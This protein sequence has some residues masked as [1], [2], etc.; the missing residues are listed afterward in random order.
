MWPG[1]PKLSISNIPINTSPEVRK[2]IEDL[3][4]VQI[5]KRISA[6][7]NLRSLGP[8]AEPAI[9][10]LVSMLGDSITVISK[11]FTYESPST[12]ATHA[13][14]ELE[15]KAMELVADQLF[16]KDKK[17][18]RGAARTIGYFK[19]SPAR[20]ELLT[21]TIH[22]IDW[23]VREETAKSLG[24][25]HTCQTIKPLLSLIK[26]TS[27][28][29]RA[30]AV[31]SLATVGSYQVIDPVIEVALNDENAYVRKEAA[32]CFSFLGMIMSNEDPRLFDIFDALDILVK[33]ENKMVRKKASW[34]VGHI[35]P[36]KGHSKIISCTKSEIDNK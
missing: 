5:N 19:K 23:K 20:V 21:R 27:I 1:G 34:L 30:T 26:D 16:N 36:Q 24:L 31:R 33:D 11:E 18:R 9:P 35:Y 6:V 15:D 8:K 22:D 3:Y 32:S 28:E 4:S 17:I 2:N 13:L 12:E 10:F 25:I 7:I 29:V 14:V